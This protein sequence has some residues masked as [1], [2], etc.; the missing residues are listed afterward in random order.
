M[1]L[2]VPVAPPDTVAM[3]RHEADD[4]LAV[5]TPERFAAVGQFYDDFTPTTDAEVVAALA[6]ARRTAPVDRRGGARSIVRTEVRIPAGGATLAGFLDV[7]DPASGLVVFVHGSGSSRHSRRNQAVA[8]HLAEHGFVTLLFDLLTEAESGDR[9]Y[10]F[11][12][13]FLT[14]RLRA[15]IEWVGS[16]AELAG[17]PMGLFGASTGAAAALRV[18]ADPASPDAH[19]RVPRRAARSGGAQRST[20]SSVRCSWSSA[21][22]TDRRWR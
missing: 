17:L 13:P 19:R 2:A 5:L 18:A 11:D 9:G 22:P 16:R 7:P 10:V 14:G 20:R 1:I 3:L 4:V 12:I 8:R 21:V 6:L 15:A